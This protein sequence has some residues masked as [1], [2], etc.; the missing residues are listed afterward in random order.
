MYSSEN[1]K[2][3]S[4]SVYSPV[5]NY[6]KK[7]CFL[8]NFTTHFTLIGTTFIGVWPKKRPLAP[9]M[10]LHKFHQST[11]VFNPIPPTNRHGRV[12]VTKKLDLC[13]KRVLRVSHMVNNCYHS[14]NH[15]SCTGSSQSVSDSDADGNNGYFG[16]NQ[17]GQFAVPTARWMFD[18]AWI[19][20]QPIRQ[21]NVFPIQSLPF[22]NALNDTFA[23]FSS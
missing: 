8:T 14:K 7:F 17:R 5:S 11:P 20:M 2:S 23:F 19:I 16:S 6:R 1:L 10:N 3:S 21:V 13:W 15:I 12:V 9:F 18:V 4:K 22:W